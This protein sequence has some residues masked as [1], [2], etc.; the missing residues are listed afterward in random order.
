MILLA[1]LF[2]ASLFAR[3]SCAGICPPGSACTSWY[4]EY[5]VNCAG[6]ITDFVSVHFGDYPLG[7]EVN[8]Q[9]SAPEWSGMDPTALGCETETCV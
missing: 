7:F 8:D 4:I 3:F 5:E 9:N 2:P 1:L 6:E